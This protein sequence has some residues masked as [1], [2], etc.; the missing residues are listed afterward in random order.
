[1]SKDLGIPLS[2]PPRGPWSI[3]NH[4]GFT[5]ALQILRASVEPGK[6]SEKLQTFDTIRRLRSTFSNICYSSVGAHVDKYTLRVTKARATISPIIQPTPLC[7]TYLS[8]GWKDV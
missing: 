6:F 4:V 2:Y 5:V 8:M 1:M 7:L 3:D